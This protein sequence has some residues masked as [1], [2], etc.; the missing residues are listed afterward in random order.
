MNNTRE[1]IVSV[2]SVA[3]KIIIVVIAAMLIFKYAM[4]AYDYGYRIFS[5]KPMGS[6]E[7]WAVEI[8]ITSDMKVKEIGELL[9]SKGLIRDCVLFKFQER[10]SENHGKI[11]AGTYELNTNMTTEQMISIMSGVD[12][13]ASD[14][15][16][17]ATG[18]G[19]ETAIPEPDTKE[20]ILLEE[21]NPAN[22][23]ATEEASE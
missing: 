14:E 4:T 5:E 19:D 7:G 3:I 17:P 11:V 22:G 6:G 13:T 1:I 16:L 10:L 15:A 2:F 9:E 20:D 12:E 21:G 23:E 8:T 18:I